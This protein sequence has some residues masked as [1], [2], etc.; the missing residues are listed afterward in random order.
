[1]KIRVLLFLIL[2]FYIWISGP[3][4]FN[5]GLDHGGSGGYVSYNHL[6][7]A[8]L[9]GKLHLLGEP[10]PE[11]IELPNPYDPSTNG[12]LR[13]HDASLYKGKYYMYFGITPALVLYLPFKVLTGGT[14]TDTLASIIFMFGSVLWATLILFHIKN[15]YLKSIPRWMLVTSIAVLGL[16]VAPSIVHKNCGVYAVS[17][18]CGCFFL[19]GAMYWF[20]KAIDSNS[21]FTHALFL[22]STFLGLSVGGRPQYI[23]SGIV[24]L[25]IWFKILKNTPY[26]NWKKRLKE[27]VSLIAPFLICLLLLGTY[28]YLR[29]DC[30]T[31][32]GITYQ[33][34][35]I[36]NSL[37]YPLNIN[38]IPANIYIQLFHYPKLDSVF[39]FIHHTHLPAFLRL[40]KFY[41]LQPYT[42]LFTSI[43][44]LFVPLFAWLLIK[45]NQ[46]NSFSTYITFP[47][48]E[49]FIIALPT[50][51]NL[52]VT[53][54]LYSCSKRY[55]VDLAVHLTLISSIFWSY[56]YIRFLPTL[57]RQ[58]NWFAIT[59]ISISLVT[60]TA[61]GIDTVSR[62]R[63]LLKML[64]SWFSPVS[65][66]I[67]KIHPTW[68]G[69]RDSKPKLLVKLETNVS[70]DET[71]TAQNVIDDDLNTYWEVKADK[72]PSLAFK[73][74]E[75]EIIKSIWLLSRQTSLFEC[76]KKLEAKLYL[77]ENLVLEQTFNFPSADKIR[78]QNAKLPPTKA[79]KIILT[80]SD[81]VTRNLKGEYIE[82]S[83]LNPG[84]TEILFEKAE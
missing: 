42:G 43:V 38:N 70:T 78:L 5:F 61:S 53:L 7:E 15:R 82:P 75:P 52:V 19:T 26:M 23:L 21:Y 83:Q 76:W 41:Y 65:E 57:K 37:N 16:G 49:M 22:G 39:P 10:N 34:G 66:F 69:V 11:L 44:F 2:L 71:H 74:E 36:N 63:P 72:T 54:L 58:L 32:F 59:S 51:I 62:D 45:L 73:T 12:H 18:A 33:V 8:L 13:W 3:S 60:G 56:F 14:M 20:I 25:A 27:G 28:N 40:P 17:V 29:F 4:T 24:I 1:M 79:D 50:G 47:K 30:I 81:P 80:F 48:F 31:E 67:F 46:K 55:V 84:Y 9:A 77:K 68:E 35:D 64:V 6:T